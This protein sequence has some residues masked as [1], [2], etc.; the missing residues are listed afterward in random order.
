MTLIP[1]KSIA[2]AAA[3][4]PS[5]FA[6]AGPGPYPRPYNGEVLHL[7]IPFGRWLGVQVR[8]HVSVL[9]LL[10]IAGGY[11]E[12]VTGG[13]VRG[14]GLWL[15]LVAAILVREIARAIAAAYAGAPVRAL[16]L[17]PFGAVIALEPRNGGLPKASQRLIAW[18][19]SAANLLAALLL[20]G[21]AYGVAP[22]VT[23]FRQPWISAE[24]V[25]RSAVWLQIAYGA[26]N[27]LP[28][29]RFSAGKF[30]AA[31]FPKR[32]KPASAPQGDAS[33]PFPTQDASG[34]GGSPSGLLGKR[35]VFGLGTAIAASLL[36][37]GIVLG[38]VWPVLLGVTLLF[39]NYV[40][41]VAAVGAADATA[42]TVS[43]VMLTEY[44]P[45]PA[46]GTLRDALLRTTHS[47]QDTFPVVRGDRLVGWTSRTA[48]STRLQTEG[49]SYLQGAMSRSLQLAEP[50]ERLPEAL[51]R[52][53]T[54]G[55]SE[56]IPVVQDGAMVGI[57]TPASLERAMG[58][59]RLTHLPTPDR[60]D[61]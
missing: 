18:I 43:D 20:L 54:L 10:A 4:H 46:S 60:R 58:Q 61:S 44:L 26:I 49:D 37:V 24:H 53:A 35:P 17:L 2:P 15:V 16:Y 41:R 1:V 23:L 47:L 19:G 32:A 39:M 34:R 29:K 9:L 55:A 13:V 40:S 30:F 5:P 31:A 50:D 8:I 25:L 21:F 27:L 59:I 38:L 52:A 48:L 45:L 14:L 3:A 42:L 56:F 28:A 36:I 11:S 6:S 33:G 7:S 22:E 51:R 57:L 12:L